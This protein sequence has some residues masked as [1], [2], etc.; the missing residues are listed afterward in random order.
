[1][2]FLLPALSQHRPALSPAFCI[3]VPPLSRCRCLQG[4]PLVRF[5]PISKLALGGNTWSDLNLE[6]LLPHRVVLSFT[7]LFIVKIKSNVRGKSSPSAHGEGLPVSISRPTSALPH[8]LP[9][10][11]GLEAGWE[12]WRLERR[13]PWPLGYTSQPPFWSLRAPR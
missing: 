12:S 8:P 5:S 1:M 4:S 10:R 11:E 9:S 7:F 2:D 6:L 3:L 13:W